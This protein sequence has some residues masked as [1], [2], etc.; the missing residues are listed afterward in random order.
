MITSTVISNR[1]PILM[2]FTLFLQH[3]GS[4][5]WLSWADS[6]WVSVNR[7]V[8]VIESNRLCY[9]PWYSYRWIFTDLFFDK[10]HRG[11]PDGM[12]VLNSKHKLWWAF[13]R[14]WKYKNIY[15]PF[16][17]KPKKKKHKKKKKKKK[18]NK[19]TNKNSRHVR[20]SPKMIGIRPHPQ[21]AQRQLRK[22]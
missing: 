6:I 22:K 10:G 11:V 3:T 9:F 14:L 5:L 12:T 21:I 19:Q 18:K 8:V 4:K 20:L 1:I 7:Y 16:H 2:Y 17:K 15:S 13:D